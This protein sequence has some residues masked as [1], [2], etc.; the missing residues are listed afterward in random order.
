MYIELDRLILNFNCMKW[1]TADT[2][3]LYFTAR[4]RAQYLYALQAVTD[5]HGVDANGLGVSSA[6]PH[7]LD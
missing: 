6:Q 2:E 7:R 3:R 5:A 4:I 1:F